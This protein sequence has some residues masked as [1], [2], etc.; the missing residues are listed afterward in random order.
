ML[1]SFEQIKAITKGVTKVEQENGYYRF[2]RFTEAQS[3]VYVKA[4]IQDFYNKS[5][6]SAGVRL[7]FRTDSKRVAFHFRTK[8]ASACSSAWFDVYENKVLIKHFGFSDDNNQE[9]QVEILL[10]AGESDV[11]IYLP[12]SACTDLSN[13]EVDDNAKL[14]PLQRKK[15]M[16]CFGDSITHGYYAEYPSLTY[17]AHIARLLDADEINKGIG[18]ERFRPELLDDPDPIIPDVITVGYSTN[19]WNFIT[20]AE[21]EEKCTAF[22]KKLN[23]LYPTASI[24]AISPV[25]RTDATMETP[26]G[27]PCYT[28]H[29]QMKLICDNIPNVVLIRGWDLV[30]HIK[31][32]YGDQRVHPNDLGFCVYAENLYREILKK[33]RD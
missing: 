18:G 29:D 33:E 27:S 3:Q 20:P 14:V 26:Y 2:F 11:E 32:F 12:W 6:G 8:K 1:L 24:Y 19:D 30:P 25:W 28:V 9:G 22:Y 15:K 5:F 23:Q 17:A 21:F 13:V 4:G 31:D 16:L 10:Q 7:A